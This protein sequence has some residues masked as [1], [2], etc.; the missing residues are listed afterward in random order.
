M[1]IPNGFTL[2]EILITLGIIGVVAAITLPTLI[3]NYQKSVAENKL[4]TAYSILSNT[5][6]M[7]NVQNDLAFIPDDLYTDNTNGWDYD[8]SE[9]VFDKYFA[10]NLKIVKEYTGANR[11]DTCNQKGEGCHKNPSY[12]CIILPNDTGLCFAIH[13]PNSR[14]AF[15]I[16]I[17]PSKKRLV[18]GK[19]I[20]G[21][22]VER[23]VT[24]NDYNMNISTGAICSKEKEYITNA[25][26]S[27]NN[28]TDG[29]DREFWC[30]CLIKNNNWEIPDDYP[31]RF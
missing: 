29:T 26:I 13:Y 5:L 19:D 12:K 2:A 20:F 11:I 4:K 24:S 7:I 15:Q 9:K 8:M 31:I 28:Y 14:M 3:S 23:D 22:V 25:C 17:S 16:I 10:S 27:G 30:T 21:F 6:Q 1:K 18:A